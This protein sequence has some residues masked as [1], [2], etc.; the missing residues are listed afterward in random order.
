MKRRTMSKI[1]IKRWVKKRDKAQRK[2]KFA[3]GF[4]NIFIKKGILKK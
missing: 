4:R 1:K 2:Q 3:E